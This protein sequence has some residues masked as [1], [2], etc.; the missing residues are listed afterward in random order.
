MSTKNGFYDRYD[1]MVL[2][3]YRKE[4]T[5]ET[6]ATV[7]T[8]ANDI[9][10]IDNKFDKN[11][12]NIDEK[13]NLMPNNGE[14]LADEEEIK[15]ILKELKLISIKSQQNEK[16]THGFSSLFTYESQRYKFLILCLIWFSVCGTYNGIYINLK[17]QP[18]NIYLSGIVYF[19]VDIVA[20]FVSGYLISFKVL[21]R[22]NSVIGL[23]LIFLGALFSLILF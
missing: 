3:E 6:F 11:E 2:S 14:N 21:G 18:T 1:K 12:A 5:L 17:N 20:C 16:K 10:N 9:T 23:Y 22:I 4:L 13:E 7:E 8:F 15:N 19:I